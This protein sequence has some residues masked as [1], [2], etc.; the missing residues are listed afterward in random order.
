M[1]QAANLVVP[2]RPLEATFQDEFYRS[3][4]T[5]LNNQLYIS[6][7]WSGTKKGGRVD[8]RVRTMPWA[9]EILRD[10]INIEEHLARFKPGGNYY[11]W[12]QAQEIQDYV[13]LDFRRSKPQKIRSMLQCAVLPSHRLL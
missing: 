12:L 6:S 1:D 2:S 8:F 7:E 10:G 5:L 13:V 9:V 4:Y 11:P 3:C